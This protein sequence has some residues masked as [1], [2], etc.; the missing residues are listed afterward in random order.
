MI[1]FDFIYIYILVYQGCL[2]LLPPIKCSNIHVSSHA[3]VVY[4]VYQ[5]YLTG[6]LHHEGSVGL[7]IQSEGF[8]DCTVMKTDA[9][10]WKTIKMYRTIRKAGFYGT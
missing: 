8:N 1:S 9:E 6:S 5:G 7:D 2:T 10:I 3:L 4:S